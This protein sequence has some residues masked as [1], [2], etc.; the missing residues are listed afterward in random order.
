M[1]VLGEDQE[2][3]GVQLAAW[4]HGLGAVCSLSLTP[5]QPWGD[6]QSCS[7]PSCCS[8]GCDARLNPV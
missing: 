7:L 4:V 8:T 1:W 2:G 6:E 3:F 5:C